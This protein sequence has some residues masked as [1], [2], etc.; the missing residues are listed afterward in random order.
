M[1]DEKFGLTAILAAASRVERGAR[2]TPRPSPPSELIATAV[3]PRYEHVRAWGDEVSPTFLEEL[4]RKNCDIR[5]A[6]EAG[7]SPKSLLK[8]DFLAISGGGDQGAFAAGVLSG[9]ARRGDRPEFE[10]VTGV[11]AGALAAPFAF[12][13]PTYDGMLRD[14]Y[15]Q[16]G[17]S[18]LYKSRGVRGY[19]SDAFENNSPMQKMVESYATDRLLDEIAQGYQDGRRLI[20]LTTNIDAQRPVIW[21]LSAVAASA[22]PDRREMFAKILL[23]SSAVPGIFPPIYFPVLTSDGATYSEMHVDGGVTA[24][25]IFV[26]PETRLI[27]IEDRLFSQRRKRALHVIRNSKIV[28]EHAYTKARSLPI[29]SRAF[30]TMVKYQ[31]VA[32]LA[33]L[34]NF[35]VSNNTDFRYCAVPASLTMKNAGPFDKERALDL[36][37]S[38]EKVGEADL[39]SSLPPNSPSSGQAF[40]E[41]CLQKPAS[42]SAQ[43]PQANALSLEPWAERKAKDRVEDDRPL[44]T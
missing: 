23:A 17:A 34:Y 9:W 39:W 31:V 33:R 3:V 25:L 30:R 21:D 6:A 40:I 19:F 22:E 7:R 36:F 37:T 43:K 14:V 27:Q 41:D 20:I 28:P 10:A 13:G 11:S 32:D 29:T 8:A 24:Q 16:Y 4:T 2:S 18:D 35:T 1:V 38:G 15:T 26:P 12:V 44:Q 42:S 5:A